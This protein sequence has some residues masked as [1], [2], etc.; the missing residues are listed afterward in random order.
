MSFVVA[1][2]EALAAAA[3]DLLNIGSVL[4]AANAAAASRTTGLAGRR[5]R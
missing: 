2:P 4:S 5:C 3:S 1:V